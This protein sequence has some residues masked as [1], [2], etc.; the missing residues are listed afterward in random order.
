MNVETIPFKNLK[1]GEFF[2]APDE[3]GTNRIYQPRQ[4]GT[5]TRHLSGQFASMEEFSL[6]RAGNREFQP[7]DMVVRFSLD[8][9]E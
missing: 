9:P 1:Q 6:A 7:L 2:V 5:G 8:D 3:E 4:Q